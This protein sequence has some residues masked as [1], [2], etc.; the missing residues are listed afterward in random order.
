MATITGG[1]ILQLVGERSKDKEASNVE[2]VNVN[3]NVDELRFEKDRIVAKYT[4]TTT[5]AP[6]VASIKLTGEIYLR[7]DD[8]GRRDVE[9][10]W[11]KT[12]GLPPAFAEDLLTSITYTASAVGTLVAFGLGVSAPIN[13]PRARI[14]AAP[15]PQGQRPGATAG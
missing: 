7:E 1:R 2:S 5:Y 9:E 6:D 12:K 13:I 4:H 11:K 10:Q 14:S 15:A 8:K 3:V